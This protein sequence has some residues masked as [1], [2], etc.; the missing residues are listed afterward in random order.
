MFNRW[1]IYLCIFLQHTVILQ[2]PI[3]SIIHTKTSTSDTGRAVF[4]KVHEKLAVKFVC[5]T[6]AVLTLK[7]VCQKIYIYIYDM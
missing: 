4:D 7:L 2:T 6:P 5:F 1:C 3:G